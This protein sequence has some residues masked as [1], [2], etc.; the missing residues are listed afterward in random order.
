MD[1]MTM[2][3]KEVAEA[4]G[5]CLPTAHQLTERADFPVIRIGRRKIIPVD[6]F[7]AWL[8]AQSTPVAAI[9]RR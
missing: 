8:A 2:T 7:K 5:V 3:T 1:K 9:G 4:I 6:Q